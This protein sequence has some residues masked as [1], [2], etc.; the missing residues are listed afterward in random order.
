MVEIPPGVG[1]TH[2]HY[3]INYSNTKLTHKSS[4]EVSWPYTNKIQLLLTHKNKIS[5]STD[6]SPTGDCQESSEINHFNLE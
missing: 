1:D 3:K 5:C 4:T 6:G 2:T